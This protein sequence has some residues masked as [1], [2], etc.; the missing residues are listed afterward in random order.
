MRAPDR[1]RGPGRAGEPD[2]PQPHRDAL[3]CPFESEHDGI[4]AR[5]NQG[6]QKEHVIILLPDHGLRGDGR[7]GQQLQEEVSIVSCSGQAG[8]AIKR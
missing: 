2:H 6:V 3:F 4:R 7:G 1:A 8:T 5:S